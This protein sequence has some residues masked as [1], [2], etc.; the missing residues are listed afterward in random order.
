MANWI[1]LDNRNEMGDYD[2]RRLY[3]ILRLI[4]CF[5]FLRIKIQES[6]NPFRFRP[7][8]NSYVLSINTC[9]FLFL[10]SVH[11]VHSNSLDKNLK[12]GHP[13]SPLFPLP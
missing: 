8:N 7:P 5:I 6:N 9:I 11:S 3:L 4:R 10:C 1:V 2:I 12:G 13:P